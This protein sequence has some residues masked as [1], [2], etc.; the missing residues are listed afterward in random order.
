MDLLNA[1]D[2]ATDEFGR[3]V[4]LVRLHDW[5]RPTS[6]PDWDVYYLVAHV[7]GGNRFAVLILGGMDASDAIGEVMSVPQ[8]GGDALWAWATTSAAQVAA[9]RA[10]N[11]LDSPLDHP[12]GEITG[13]E[14]LEFRVF[15][16]TLHAWDL[17]R[18]MGTEDQIGHDLVDAVLHI[19]ENGPS[20]VGFGIKASGATDA[21]APPQARLLDLTGR[22]VASACKSRLDPDRRGA[23]G[24]RTPAARRSGAPSRH[25]R[26]VLARLTPVIV[27]MLRRRDRRRGRRAQCWVVYGG[28]S[29][30]REVWSAIPRTTCPEG[31]SATDEFTTLPAAAAGHLSPP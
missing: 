30:R 5:D 8:L 11:A 21:N 28:D 14:F 19:V 22:A 2:A 9:F 4:A 27:R 16:V 18:A 1:L 24:S 20:G 17:A 26:R 13:R 25:S 23:A 12:L 29:E 15:D 6:C 31:T 7:V 3:R 10:E